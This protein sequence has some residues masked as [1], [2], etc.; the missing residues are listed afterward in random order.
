[1][2]SI[3][4]AFDR[5]MLLLVVFILWLGYDAWKSHQRYLVENP[6]YPW[7]FDYMEYGYVLIFLAAV[8]WVISAFRSK[9]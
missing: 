8:Y 1:M 6:T 9:A 2:K 3:F 7:P 5:L 4:V